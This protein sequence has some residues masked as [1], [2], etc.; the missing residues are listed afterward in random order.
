MSIFIR[1]RAEL[2]QQLVMMKTQNGTPIRA[3]ARQFAISRNMVRRILRKHEAFREKGHDILQAERQ[4]CLARR[5]SKLDPFEKNIKLLLEKY[6]KITGE[7]LFEELRSAGY[8]GGISIL[9]DRLRSLR[10]VPKQ[11]P[12]VRF[13]TDPGIQGQMDWSP[14]RIKFLRTGSAEVQCFSY[15]LGFSRRQFIDFTPRRDFFTL[16][17]RHDDAF[18]YFGGVPRQCLYDS[19]KTVVLRWEAGRP[20]LN[21]A[22]SAFITHYHCRP[23]ICQRARPETKGKIERPFQYV[24]GNLLCGREFQDLEDLRACARWWL[25]E[26][27]DMHRHDT[28]GRPPLELFMEQEQAA[29]QLL[30]LHPYDCA[31]VALRVCNLDGYIDFETNRYPVPYDHVTDILT[32]KATEHEILIYS[33]ELSLVVRHERVP[34]GSRIILDGADIHR[35]KS[36]R[37]GLESV[38]SQFLELGEQ[39]ED[40]LRGLKNSHSKN[41]GFHARYILH[42]KERY[43]CDDINSAL[44]HACRYHAY[45]C[46][47]V[48][49][50][51][52]AK[53][54]P[55]PLESLRNERASQELRRAL[56]QIKQRPLEEYDVLL[57]LNHPEK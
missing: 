52:V 48:E 35:L 37:Y 44:A 49:R 22:F 6:P 36:S 40:F 28:T 29:L 12:I 10:P 13:E 4:V 16:I 9:R 1:N 14:Y 41:A 45:D 7:R 57:N 50:I 21:P 38:Q 53:A 5:E 15:I 2:E 43:H 17:R 33:P 46:K 27:S 30:P 24:E 32:M 11:T 42:L 18:T 54:T 26:K 23:I 39:A 47:A 34:A 56:P 20:L 8:D 51:L 31:E 19:E 25:K 55:R 3:L